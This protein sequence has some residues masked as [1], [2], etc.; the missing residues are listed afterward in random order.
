LHHGGSVPPS[1]VQ[2]GKVYVSLIYVIA[3]LIGISL[4]GCGWICYTFTRNGFVPNKW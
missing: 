1:A 3:A 4:A 2:G